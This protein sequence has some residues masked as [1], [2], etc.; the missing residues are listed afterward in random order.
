MSERSRIIFIVVGVVAYL[1]FEALIGRGRTDA[2]VEFDEVVDRYVS[3]AVKQVVTVKLNRGDESL[4]ISG[5]TNNSEQLIRILGQMSAADI[6][7]KGSE[8][9]DRDSMQFV[10]DMGSGGR[11]FSVW[12]SRIDI[13]G[14]LRAQNLVK[15][16]QL[17]GQPG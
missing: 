14:D 13:E 15:L 1:I 8:A 11:E 12:V 16:F 3:G 7:S 6:F 4:S 5:S 17:H 2:Q 10:V 9:G